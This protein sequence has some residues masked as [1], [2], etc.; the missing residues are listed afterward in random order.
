MA[1]R[2]LG[3]KNRRIATRRVRRPIA[4]EPAKSNRL[5]LLI[6]PLRAVMPE[7][8]AE[9]LAAHDLAFRQRQHG[10]LLGIGNRKQ[11]V[12]PTLM[13]PPGLRSGCSF[14]SRNSLSLWLPAARRDNAGLRSDSECNSPRTQADRCW[15]DQNPASPLASLARELLTARRGKVTV[16]SMNSGL[17]SRVCM[18]MTFA[19]ATQSMSPGWQGSLLRRL[20]ERTS[21][22]STNSLLIRSIRSRSSGEPITAGPSVGRNSLGHLPPRTESWQSGIY[23]SKTSVLGAM[24]MADSARGST[25][26]TRSMNCRTQTIGFAH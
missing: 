3:R 23:T 9:P 12:A 17:I 1:H 21:T 26:S 11:H 13:R 2:W 15:F 7:Q 8:T 22:T 24:P 18:M 10:R 6:R 14:F 16:R 19:E 5:G 20:S 25:I 4:G